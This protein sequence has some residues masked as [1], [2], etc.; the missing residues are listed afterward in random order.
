VWSTGALN[1]NQISVNVSGVY[2][3][4]VT[5]ANGCSS[6]SVPVVVTVLPKPPIPVIVSSGNTFI[7]Q[8]SSVI[9]TGPAGYT[10]LWNTGATTQSISVN[11]SGN[12]ILTVFNANGCSESNSEPVIV[13]PLPVTPTITTSGPLQF[14]QGGS[15]TL[16]AP[17]GL[18]YLW[19]NG[20]VSQSTNVNISGNYTVTVTN[21][22]GCSAISVPT[23]VT[24]NALPAIPIITASGPTTFCQGGSVTLTAPAGLTYL[25]S[26]GST[27]QSINVNTPG[28]FSVT[29]TNANG[30]SSTSVVATVTVNVLP[31]IPIV[32]TSGPTTFCQGGSVTL[33]APAGF[34]YL[35]S[36]GATTQSIIV[37][38]PGDYSVTISNAN[39]CIAISSATTV[40]VNPLPATPVISASGPVT[41]C[42]GGSVTLTAPAGFTYLWSNGSTS[43]S[44]NIN[45]TGNF[46]VT[47]TNANVCSSASGGTTVTVNPLPAT[48]VI[49]AS[50]P[51]TLCQGGSVTLTAPAGFTY[52]WSNGSTSQSINVSSPGNYSVT[53]TNANSCSASSAATT[54]TVNPLPAIPTVTASGPVSFCQGGSVTLTASA[55]FSYLWSNG[56]TTQSIVVNTSGS[57]TV[58]VTN[59]NN[60]SSVSA[61]TTVT[62][63]ALPPVPV[64]TQTGNTLFSS[65]STGNQWYFNGTLI[66]GATA[67]S[68]TYTTGGDYSVTVTTPGGC[69]VSSMVYTAS[70]NAWVQVT[71]TERFY[72]DLFPN[73]VTSQ[74][75]ISYQLEQPHQV[76][77]SLIDANGRV[78]TVQNPVMRTAGTYTLNANSI[79][80]RLWRGVYILR[81]TI[82]NKKVTRMLVKL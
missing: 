69:S 67:S 53:I 77:I 82:D 54:V 33:T 60:C 4:T 35:W 37:N 63:N 29:V 27:S 15:V 30:C 51:T 20:S 39:N 10:Y 48:P 59:T 55:G 42:Q 13:M 52:L 75:T 2:T 73:P 36:N 38:T 46:S 50:G 71:D 32:T 26:N 18:T 22:N 70:R 81:F 8:G 41:F 6:T 31:A 12:Y 34:T 61:A 14:C 25:W 17:A 19:S 45:S 28:N 62:V 16:S 56:A 9:L 47:V 66:A 23:T 65:S 11:T 24:V 76:G 7:C 40:T 5:N 49:T 72:Y 80:E 57:Y 79:A 3:V 74:L 78:I 68:Y 1:T 43:Q 64:I 44:I 58:T 21:A